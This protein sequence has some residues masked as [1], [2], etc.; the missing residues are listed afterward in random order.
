MQ[1]AASSPQGER[2]IITLP[3]HFQLIAAQKQRAI[4]AARAKFQVKKNEHAEFQRR[5]L[6]SVDERRREAVQRM[7]GQI[8]IF[9][10]FKRGRDVSLSEC[11]TK[12]AKMMNQIARD[13]D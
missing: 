3:E 11:L 4:Q 2:R 1:V 7:A 9:E 12:A 6:M 8:K 5:K 13:A 10:E